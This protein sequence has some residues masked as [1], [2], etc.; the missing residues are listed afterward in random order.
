MFSGNLELDTLF[1]DHGVSCAIVEDMLA[2]ER[3][4]NQRCTPG[5]LPFSDRQRGPRGRSALASWRTSLP[6]LFSRLT[7]Q[8]S[9]F[10]SWTSLIRGL[11]VETTTFTSS[12]FSPW[13]PESTLFSKRI[14]GGLRFNDTFSPTSRIAGGNRRTLRQAPAPQRPDVAHSMNNSASCTCRVPHLGS[15]QL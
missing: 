8:T 15:S 13:L 5:Q 4:V 3:A 1:E 7:L 9:V 14:P 12:T 2:L 6:P 10:S 11:K